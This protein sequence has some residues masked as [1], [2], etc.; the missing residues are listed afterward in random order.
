MPGRNNEY[1]VT[2]VALVDRNSHATLLTSPSPSPDVNEPPQFPNSDTR[3]RSVTEN[4][5]AGQNV[6]AP[7]SASDPEKDSLTYTL[8]GRDSRY[9]D[10]DTSTGQILAKSELNYE[11]RKS[12][13]VTMSVR[14]S[15]NVDGNPDAVTDDTYRHHHQ[16]DR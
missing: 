9:F 14:D 6:G 13:S 12:Y 7:V 15:K 1:H 5:A 2:V 3:I 10:I 16:R 8:S 11:G 4:T